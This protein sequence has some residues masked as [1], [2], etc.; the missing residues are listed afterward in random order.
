MRA[1]L[2]FACLVV[3]CNKGSPE[4]GGLDP[5]GE[6]PKEQAKEDVKPKAKAKEVAAAE[7]KLGSI[8]NIFKDNEAA[9]DQQ[10]TGKRLRF[11]AEVDV[12]RKAKD[13]DTYYIGSFAMHIIGGKSAPVV[14]LNLRPD[15]VGQA[16]QLKEWDKV[17]IEGKCL[18][19]KNDGLNRGFVGYGFHIPF[20]DCVIVTKLKS[21]G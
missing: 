1:A 7:A 19:R 9:G 13:G 17:V 11:E 3:G 15:Q 20:E 14:I 12:V 8:V 16:T 18:G 2:L 10:F 4:S 6:K 5:F 21:K